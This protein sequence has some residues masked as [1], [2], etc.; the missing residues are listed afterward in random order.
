MFQ[1]KIE[2]SLKEGDAWLHKWSKDNPTISPTIEVKGD[3]TSNVSHHYITDPTKSLSAMGRFGEGAGMWGRR[4][5]M[6]M[7]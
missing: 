2:E 7:S 5:N 3:P 1:Q 6:R 4:G